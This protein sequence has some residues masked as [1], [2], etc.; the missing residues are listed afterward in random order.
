M[1]KLSIFLVLCV[2]FL[3]AR[4]IEMSETQ[5][6]DLGVRTQKAVQV[7]KIILPSLNA[8]VILAPK[9]IITITPRVMG[10]IADVYVKKFDKVAQGEKIFSLRSKELL[11]LQQEYLSLSLEHQNKQQNYQRD[12]KLYETGLIA[13]KRLLLT[14]QEMMQSKL[15]FESVQNKLLESGF[16]KK[17]LEQIQQSLSPLREI[18]YYAS[19]AGQIY[20]ID[21]NVGKSVAHDAK[22]VTLYADG[23]R[24]IEFEVPLGMLE[25]ISLGD[26]CSFE[27]YKAKIVALS[28]LVNEESQSL[29]V[30]ALIENPQDIRIHSVYQ[31]SLE[32]KTQGKFFRVMKSALVFSEGDAYVFKKVSDGF[33]ALKVGL[34]SEDEAH[35]TIDAELTSTDDVAVS[36]TVALLSAMEQENE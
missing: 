32:T 10:V 33:E 6:G 34:V 1:N 25:F 8:K 31:V 29:S 20:A 5:A 30:R 2:S 15:L 36:S 23:A 26:I 11:E 12:E 35:Y 19:R 18:S 16:N 21:A 24:S 22:I 9:D 27:G 13:H 3:D 7:E 17:M 14:Q 4:L 28:D